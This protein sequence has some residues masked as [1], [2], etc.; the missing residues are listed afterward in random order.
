[1]K[2]GFRALL[3]RDRSL[4]DQLLEEHARILDGCVR[5]GR[6]AGTSSPRAIRAAAAQLIVDFATLLP[7][8][9]AD[10]E[11]SMMPRMERFGDRRLLE[12]L[13]L[14]I[15]H[16]LHQEWML[17]PLLEGWRAIVDDP[18]PS[19]CRALAPAVAMLETQVRRHLE[20]EEQ[21][22]YTALER[23]SAEEQERI[24]AE[25]RRRR[26]QAAERSAPAR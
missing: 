15:Q 11:M 7:L 4:R 2:Y 5:A 18:S 12:A 8:H 6:L 22:I 23:L 14:M 17:A 19:R 16:H 26:R 9:L 10:D 13:T 21:F 25:M 1:M 24:L 3:V 20:H